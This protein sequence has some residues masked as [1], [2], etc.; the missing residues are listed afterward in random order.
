MIRTFEL[1][2]ERAHE[3]FCLRIQIG[4]GELR[5]G[6]AEHLGAAIGYAVPISDAHDQA[7]LAMERHISLRA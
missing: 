6:A 1:L 2:G 7:L 3:R 5:T 4:N